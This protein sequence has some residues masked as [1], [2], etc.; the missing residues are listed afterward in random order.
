MIFWI[1]LVIAGNFLSRSET[2]I[3]VLAPI[4]VLAIAIPVWWLVEFARK[5]LDR[6][7]LFKEWGTITVGLTLTPISIIIIETILAGIAAVVI[8]IFIGLQ[9]SRLDQILALTNSLDPAQG[10]LEAL[11]QLLS[12]LAQDPLV[13]AGIF[14]IIGL[15]APF[16]EELIKPLA[17]WF[18]LKPTLSAKDGFVL[19]L[20]SGGAFALLESAGMVNQISV[21]DWTEA[22]LLRSATGVL[23]IGLSGLVGYGIGRARSEKRWGFAISYLLAAALLHGL[24][25]SMALVS[26]FTVSPLPVGEKITGFA[27]GEIISIISMLVIFSIVAYITLRINRKLR[28]QSTQLETDIVVES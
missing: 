17:V 2:A 11:D 28:K 19:G 14:L 3:S 27:P 8:L 18:N 12:N 20:V 10:G 22:I 5:G 9:P 4:T 24:W 7:K 1:I 6:P 16:T 23:H 13:A 15:I 26:T 21:H 25:N